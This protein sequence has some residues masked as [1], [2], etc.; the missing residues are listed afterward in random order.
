MHG[1]RNWMAIEYTFAT[2]GSVYGVQWDGINE[3]WSVLGADPAKYCKS[4]G[5]AMALAEEMA[6]NDE[7]EE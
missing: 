5:Q 3:W 2:D 7:R 4:L 6:D 1:K